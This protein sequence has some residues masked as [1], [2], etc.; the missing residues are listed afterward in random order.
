MLGR[1]T[2]RCGGKQGHWEVGAVARLAGGRCP[3]PEVKQPAS[4]F[5]KVCET[6]TVFESPNNALGAR[7]GRKT[8]FPTV[9]VRDQKQEVVWH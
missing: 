1:D 8:S 4:P 2:T 3:P 7:K 6:A 9:S 5:S